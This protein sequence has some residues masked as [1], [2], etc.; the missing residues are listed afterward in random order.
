MSGGGG[1]FV[2]VLFSGISVCLW[3]VLLASCGGD[4]GGHDWRRR[5]S[6]TQERPIAPDQFVFVPCAGV[7]PDSGCLIIAAGGKRVLVEAPAGIGA[8]RI[9]GET[10]MPDGVILT[11]LQAKQIEGLDEVR[12]AVWVSGRNAELIVSGAEG[13][14]RFVEAIN[15]AYVTSDALAYVDGERRGGFSKQAMVANDVKGDGLVFD[16]GDL[17]IKAFAKIGGELALLVS[18][19]GREVL[20]TG[21]GAKLVGDARNWPG[22]EAYIGCE[23][24]DYP[25]KRLGNW[26]LEKRIYVE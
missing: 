9:A 14:G 22:G 11:S 8:G 6:K 1:F 25:V 5:G 23:Y 10:I 20:V 17:Q 12:N 4:D 15:A 3:A 24:P 13:V 7:A 26:P 2:R 21:C 19:N 16:T 18:Y